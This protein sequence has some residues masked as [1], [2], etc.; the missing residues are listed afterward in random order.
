MGRKPIHKHAMTSAARQKRYR[1]KKKRTETGAAKRER[2]ETRMQA[3]AE[4]INVAR[5]KL[6][7]STDLYA[8]IYA[9]PPWRF[10]PRSR[11]TG[12]DR[13]ADNHYET[14]ATEAIAALPVPRT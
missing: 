2:R 11:E 14:M 10:E 7:V 1:A 9:D 6:T 3:M 5:E 8:V 13:A 4:R 12:M